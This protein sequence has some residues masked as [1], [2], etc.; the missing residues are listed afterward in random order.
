[1]TNH[2]WEVVAIERCRFCGQDRDSYH[3]T[4]CSKAPQIG[5]SK[6]VLQSLDKALKRSEKMKKGET[7]KIGKWKIQKMK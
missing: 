3:T 5:I 6:S 7:K 1:M 2:D 4:E